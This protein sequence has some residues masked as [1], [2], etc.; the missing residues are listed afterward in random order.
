MCPNDIPVTAHDATRA[1]AN[2]MKTAPPHAGLR[3]VYRLVLVTIV[4]T[5]RAMYHDLGLK[6]T[7]APNPVMKVPKAIT[8]INVSSPNNCGI[9]IGGVSATSA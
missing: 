3:V 4:P 8:A 1:I 2:V 9:I 7:D 5:P 6:K